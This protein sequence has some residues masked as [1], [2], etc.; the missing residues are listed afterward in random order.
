MRYVRPCWLIRRPAAAVR[1]SGVAVALLLALPAYTAGDAALL[2]DDYKSSNHQLVI[3]TEE[4][5]NPRLVTLEEGQL[6]AWINYTR[7]PSTVVFEREVAK[8]MICHS[9]VNFSLKKGEIRSEPL[10]HGEFASFCELRPGRYEYEVVRDLSQDPFQAT[11]P[12]EWLVD[13]ERL[14]GEIIV[15][16]PDSQE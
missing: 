12:K 15:G 14:Y 10:Q 3:I 2:S 6:A 5:L 11:V 16:N 1:G 13:A 4:K 8:S 7:Q 9:L